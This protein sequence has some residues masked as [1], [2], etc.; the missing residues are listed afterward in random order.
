MLSW[1]LNQPAVASVAGSKERVNAMEGRGDVSVSR[2]SC[3]SLFPIPFQPGWRLGREWMGMVEEVGSMVSTIKRGDQVIAPF[4]F[5][6]G[7][8]EIAWLCN[9]VKHPMQRMQ[10]L[11]RSPNSGTYPP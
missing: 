1:V 2:C 11:L 10:G 9:R 7:T 6:D 4:A 8:C 5:S 3:L